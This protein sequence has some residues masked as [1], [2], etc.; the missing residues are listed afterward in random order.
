MKFRSFLF[1]FSIYLKTTALVA[2]MTAA[3]NY[4]FSPQA[5]AAGTENTAP[6]ANSTNPVPS[7]PVQTPN[8]SADQVITAYSLPPELSKKADELGLIHFRF[9]IF[10]ILFQLV[11]LLLFLRWRLGPKF[12]DW[13][14]QTSPRRWAQGMIFA[15]SFIITLSVF[16][17]PLEIYEQSVSR[18][19]GLSIQGWGSWAGDWLK[20]QAVAVIIMFIFIS[21]LYWVIRRSPRRWWLYFWM[22]SLPI[23]FAVIFVQ[24]LVVDPLFHKFEPLQSKD[25]ALTARLQELVHKVGQNIPPE[26]MFWMGGRKDHYTQRLRNRTRRLQAHCCMGHDD[27]QNDDGP[28]HVCNGP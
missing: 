19:Y 25:P 9:H 24:P 16:N 15:P 7:P 2:I 27:R 13:A 8:V 14:E 28:N 23:L 12:R 26:R 3:V 22:A 11:T 5:T 17:L 10:G 20:G 18:R 6:L 4:G 1:A 21:V